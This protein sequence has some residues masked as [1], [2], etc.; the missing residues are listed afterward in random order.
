MPGAGT[1]GRT[2]KLDKQNISANIRTVNNK[3]R[4]ADGCGY[5]LN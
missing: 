5:D 4:R 1:G 2:K 3:H